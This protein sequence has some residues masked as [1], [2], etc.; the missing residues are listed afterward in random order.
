ML[1]LK[2]P[3][4]I[5]LNDALFQEKKLKVYVLRLDLIHPF[6]SGNNGTS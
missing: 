6:V 5:Q 2:K 3:E 1:E 4:L